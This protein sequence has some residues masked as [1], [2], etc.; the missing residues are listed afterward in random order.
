MNPFDLSAKLSLFL[1]LTIVAAAQTYLYHICPNTT[2]FPINST[3][4]NNIDS[5]LTSLSTN[6][7]LQD[8]FSRDSTGN[9][10]DEVY[11]LSLCTAGLSSDICNTCVS[12]A[13]TDTVQRCPVEKTA[14]V[15]Y[16]ECLLQYSSQNIFSTM[17]DSPTVYLVNTQNITDQERFNELLAKTMN[18][19]ITEA[20]TNQKGAQKFA[21]KEV[22]FTAFET[23]FTFSQCTPDLSAVD[24]NRCLQTAISQLPM[25]CAGLQGGRILMPSCSVRYEIYPFYNVTGYQREVYPY[26]NTT[27]IGEFPTSAPPPP[28]SATPPP[29]S[30]TIPE[31]GKGNKTT[32]VKVIASVSASIIGVLLVTF[33]IY[34]L[35]KR[36]FGSNGTEQILHT[37]QEVRLLNLR[38]QLGDN[39]SGQDIHNEMALNSKDCPAFSFVTIYEATKHFSYDSKLGKGGFG[40]V[41]KGTLPDGKEIAVKRLSRTSG[42]G[43][44]EFMTEVTLIAR[45]QHRN[46]VRLLGCCLEKTEKLLIYEYM[47]NKSLDVFLFDSNMGILLDW[48]K[49]FNIINGVAR[50]LLY[51]HEDSRLRVIHRDLKASN[52]LLDYEMNPKISDFGMAR[53]FGG[54]DIN[55]TNRVVGTYGYM[56]PE[57]AMEGLFSVKSDVFSFGVLV[58]EIISGKRNNRF[59]VSKE[60]ESLLTFAWKLWSEGQGLELVDTSLVQSSVAAEVLKCIHI[61]LLCVQDDPIERPTMSSVVVMLGSDISLPVPKHCAFSVGQFVAKSAT[62]VVVKD[63]SVNEVSLSNVSPR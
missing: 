48:K 56:S 32:R 35:W 39:H 11:G 63:C 40:S 9:P 58:L 13:T 31:E 59:Y 22:N 52:V 26:Y 61:G 14:I 27:V 38:R 51:L 19:T 12:K 43:L 60:G 21:V 10:P 25:C 47:P 17:M 15:W 29:L 18:E 24:C 6:T 46:L 28:P 44:Q 2:T 20:S 45:L 62:S 5:V 23:I 41:Y 49:R 1:S 7:Y 3:Y 55:N 30:T 36:K 4:Q 53:I 50:G 16:D 34:T 37:S 33:T 54:N 42:Q 8:G 57:Y